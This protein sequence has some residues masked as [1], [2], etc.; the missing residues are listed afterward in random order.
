[1]PYVD[2]ESLRDRLEREHQLPI[3]DAVSL[4]RKVASALD[5]A[6]RHGVIHRDIKPGNILLY[7]GEPLVADFGIALAIRNAGGERLTESGIS[8][9]T[10]QYMSPEQA[11]NERTL[12]PQSDIYSLAAV[13]YEM[14]V[15]E[16]PVTG[17][18]SQAVIAR[19]LVDSPRRIRTVRKSVP[20]PVEAA[21]L[22]ALEKTPADRFR[23]AAQFAEAL[24][25]PTTDLLV[26]LR[27]PRA[28]RISVI[29]G[30]VVV[31]I[32]A[33][34][35]VAKQRSR[36]SS[37]IPLARQVTYS[38][39]A[40]SPAISPDGQFLAYAVAG[41][42]SLHVMVQDLASG[43]APT[44]VASITDATTIEW[45]PNGTQLLFGSF[46][47]SRSRG[48]VFTVP[49]TGGERRILGLANAIGANVWAYWIP[50]T[51]ASSS[52][53]SLHSD[54]DKRLLIVDL[55]TDDTVAIALRW[56][57]DGLSAGS[58]SPRGNL[59]AVSAY[60]LK[61]SQWAIAIVGR[62]GR[63]QIVVEDSI[64]LGSPR[65]SAAGDAVYYARGHTSIWRVPVSA[66]TGRRGGIPEEVV[67]QL[68]ILNRRF[69]DVA[70]FAL[71][72]DG[73]Q[74]AYA[75]GR[76][77]SNIWM[78]R[79]GEASRPVALTSGTAL[80]WSPV[81]SP[82]GRWI[83]F[84]QE[85]A[86]QA[87]LFRMPIEGGAPSQIT[88]GARVRPESSI[89]WSPDG[90]SIAFGSL[91][92]GRSKVWVATVENGQTR[93]LHRTS[94][95]TATGHLAW[96]PGSRIAYLN[97]DHTHVQLV[98]PASGDVRT[99]VPPSRWSILQSPQYSPDGNKVA[100]AWNRGAGNFG[101]WIFDLIGS[102][103][104]KKIAD[105]W[106][107]PTG[108]SEDGRYVYASLYSSPTVYRLDIRG[109]RAPEAI[110]KP[111]TAW[112]G[113]GPIA[114]V[115]EMRCAPAGHLRPNAFIC[116]AF[117]FVSDIWVID[118]FLSGRN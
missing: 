109:Q 24:S 10:P 27:G 41:G 49:R 8:V 31:M 99:I 14:L 117:D 112:R 104:A 93:V 64:E 55:G 82:D 45:S 17:A 69:T 33:I 94:L 40:F 23:T 56:N 100:V 84:A 107:W 15:G 20:A 5:H 71:T 6:H 53:V 25:A 37:A 13:A 29:I 87:E 86:G 4:T 28:V 78:L 81:V 61:A 19:L 63:T 92:Q 54:P 95:S 32:I 111:E 80:R 114:P 102:S 18:S 79:T 43:G 110:V 116:T 65:W 67:R 113:F 21:I 88:F 47:A 77:Y 9:G 48:L 11:T 3:D 96:Q 26:R 106:L 101:V 85:T 42:D 76:R 44:A 62:D 51:V 52:H 97:S 35:A 1:M 34:L 90:K 103:P 73:R 22:K 75:S 2:G 16:A 46:D 39:K 66:T 105:G 36:L 91:R 89:A 30:V 50:D 59:F 72:R 7:E 83:A 70:D 57:F 38:G 74:M 108:W 58:W 68:E 98:D 115:R 60:T 118:N 12:G